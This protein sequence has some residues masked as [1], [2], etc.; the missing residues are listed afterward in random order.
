MPS[1]G[2]A[3]EL[4]LTHRSAVETVAGNL[5]EAMSSYAAATPAGDVVSMDDLRLVSSGVDYPVF[6]AVLL[7]KPFQGSSEEW[8]ELLWEAAAHYKARRLGWS[9]WLSEEMLPRASLPLAR[10]SAARVGLRL[11]AEHHGM[12]A[13]EIRPTE[14]GL[15]E[16]LE[17]RPVSD[18]PARADFCSVI[19]RVFSVPSDIARRIY[20]SAEFWAGQYKAWVAYIGSQ[21]VATM[22]TCTTA[23]AVGVYSVGTLARYRGRGIGEAIT[24]HGLQHASNAAGISRSIL[25]ST[26]AGI[27]LYRRMGYQ[28]AGRFQVYISS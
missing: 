4:L 2:Q 15:K 13:P 6:N 7:A 24:R 23:E 8:R 3:S 12:V 14:R 5:L 1:H 25:Q 11:I 28:G 19:L 17:F 16:K 26:P 27:P 22:A 9:L 10:A 18:A 20:G 21:P